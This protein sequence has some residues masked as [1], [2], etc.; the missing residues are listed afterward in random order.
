MGENKTFLQDSM[1]Y[2][3]SEAGELNNSP[4]DEFFMCQ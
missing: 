1:F 3:Q 4:G 2:G